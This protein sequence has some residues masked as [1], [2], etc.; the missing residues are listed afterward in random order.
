M[1]YF[2]L[3]SVGK[4]SPAY[5]GLSSQELRRLQPLDQAWKTVSTVTPPCGYLGSRHASQ[6]VLIVSNNVDVHDLRATLSAHR[7]SN[8]AAL[9][10]KIEGDDQYRQ[11]TAFR[12][13]IDYAVEGVPHVDGTSGTT[14]LSS[15]TSKKT[16]SVERTLPSPRGKVIYAEDWKYAEVQEY[17][18]KSPLPC[19]EWKIKRGRE[20]SQQL[21]WLNHLR[22]KPRHRDGMMQLTSEILAFLEYMTPDQG[23][24][25]AS[26]SVMSELESR[27]AKALPNVSTKVTGSRSTGL[28]TPLS[29]INLCILLPRTALI[30]GGQSY[31]SKMQTAKNKLLYVIRQVLQQSRGYSHL[32][33]YGHNPT[34]TGLH[35][36]SGIR[37]TLTVA[38]DYPASVEYVNYYQTEFPTLRPLYILMRS[39]LEIHGLLEPGTGGL[40]SY[41]VFMMLVA[42]LKMRQGTYDRQ[43]LGD[44]LLQF[45]E[46]YST[47]DFYRRGVSVDPP[48][49]FDKWPNAGRAPVGVD[50]GETLEPYER[51]R[52]VIA[53]IHPRQPFLMC[54][55]DPADPTNDLGKLSFRIKHIQALLKEVLANLRDAIWTSDSQPQSGALLRRMVGAD[56]RY[57]E[58]QRK[59]LTQSIGR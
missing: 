47:F 24:V 7:F 39:M 30:N 50:R 10:R 3:R 11:A 31:A 16:R 51:G 59:R 6:P 19:M 45:L 41:S 58:H 26:K 44:Q 29:D 28:A 1:L 22:T 48:G 32:S 34:L 14:R 43:D 25:A 33:V 56:Y 13:D 8:R 55:Q 57:F 46:T 38:R 23:E 40:N 52:K 54:L 5:R 4:F 27:V 12:P 2:R 53:R 42:A 15:K 49:T 21:P 20:T 37:I 36:D 18:G 9:I 35:R 17:E